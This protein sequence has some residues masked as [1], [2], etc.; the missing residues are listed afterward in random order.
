MNT[1]ATI[2]AGQFENLEKRVLFSAIEVTDFG[3][4]PNDGQNDR[5]AIQ[6]AIDSAHDGDTV[7]FADGTYNVGGQI[8]LKSGINITGEN[9]LGAMLE[10][11][12]P[13]NGG[14]INGTNYAFRGVGLHDFS[15]TNLKVKSNNGVFFLQDTSNTR[16]TD[17]DFQ[18]GYGGNYYNRL[19][20]YAS[21]NQTRMRIEE[22]Y[23]HDSPD[24]DRNVELWG[25][26]DS[27][28]SYNRFHNVRDG[29]HIMEPRSN[30]QISFN[31]GTKIHRMGIEIQGHSTTTGLVVEGNVLSDWDRP[32]NDTFGLSVMMMNSPDT[33]IINN[34]LSADFSGG[35]GQS[36]PGVG[37]P[38]FG[39]AIEAG[40]SG[41][42]VS[43]NVIG[44][45]NPWACGV[46][47][48][49]QNTLVTN[50]KFY[51]HP[52]WGIMMG[53]PGN[54]GMG[55]FIDRDNQRLGRE[56]MP[57]ARKIKA[58]PSSMTGA[59]N[60]VFAVKDNGK[61]TN[62]GSSSAGKGDSKAIFWEE[63]AAKDSVAETYLSDLTWTSATGGWGDVEKDM[64]NG[65]RRDADGRA[66]T[67]AG[68]RYEKGL[69]VAV[70][71]EV[72]YDLDGK[73]K[74]FFSDI[75]IDDEVGSKGSMTFEV[76]AD[77]KRIY[78]SSVLRGNHA[79]RSLDL[80]VSG[81]HELKLLT[82][83]ASDGDNSDHGDWAAARLMPAPASNPPVETPPTGS[84]A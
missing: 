59:S 63:D 30:V 9:E 50:N 6:A 56:S 11:S 65:E 19:A 75:G 57:A 20:F 45:P 2:G 51:G 17:N 7:F 47:T 73:Y 41:G 34:Y 8:T 25:L 1:Q 81:V 60:S 5:G 49:M 78:Q 82:T 80:D 83:S 10:F 52:L 36:Q 27:S 55:S 24:S 3:A 70:N 33:K 28:Y 62:T 21:N 4:K 13:V 54:R 44:G 42:E 77:G 26:A 53:E 22:N 79:A 58:G 35:W 37:G 71:S 12:V 68:K 67:V 15:F 23:F 64:S 72:V 38:R 18:W 16:F 76:W 29:G 46:A 69:G 31:R 84:A 14:D 32:W 66:L 40:L 74:Q 43:G 39:L 61:S 48:A